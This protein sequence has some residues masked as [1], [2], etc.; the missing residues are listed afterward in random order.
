MPNAP[1]P[2]IS[3]VIPLPPVPVSREIVADVSII[4]RG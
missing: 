1:V 2:Q 4:I 3:Q